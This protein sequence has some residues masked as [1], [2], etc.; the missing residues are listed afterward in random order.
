MK[1]KGLKIF[2]Y[3][4]IFINLLIKC[5][6]AENSLIPP[7]LTIKK[8]FKHGFE[9]V[10]GKVQL[11]NGK[12]IVIHP[13]LFEGYYVKKDIPVVKGDMFITLDDAKVSILLND[14]SRVSLAANTKIMIHDVIFDIKSKYRSSHIKMPLGKGRFSVKKISDFK[15]STFKVKTANALIGVR[16]SEFII[17]AR[18]DFTRV[19]AL[20]NTR[21]EVIGTAMP[22]IPPMLLADF[23]Q[24]IIELDKVPSEAEKMPEHEIR[25]LEEDFIFKMDMDET[26]DSLTD[27][28]TKMDDHDESLEEDSFTNSYGLTGE[29]VVSSETIANEDQLRSLLASGRISERFNRNDLNTF[30][31]D[32]AFQEI[33]MEYMNE[34]NVKQE[35]MA[36]FPETPVR[37]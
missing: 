22:D 34:Q 30:D 20:E 35:E 37:N 12:V 27:K 26:D 1:T 11:V 18:I 13:I 17:R 25:I 9:K 33:I 14:Q 7:G 15:Q 21:L 32:N 3:F 2:I 10:V 8:E 23:E 19:I 36:S 6:Y 28:K 16:G 24:T 31:D 29:T 5:V 4:F